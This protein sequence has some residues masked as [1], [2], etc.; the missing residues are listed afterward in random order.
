MHMDNNP[1]NLEIDKSSKKPLVIFGLIFGTIVFLTIWYLN[2]NSD[3]LTKKQL[4]EINRHTKVIDLYVN[5]NEH[6]FLYVKFSNGSEKIMET[7][8]QIGDSLS[9]D[10]G[11]SIEYIFRKDSIIKNNYFEEARKNGQLN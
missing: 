8:Y 9:K 11:D 6:N 5:K 2:Y 1:F 10:K 4:L 7:Y 3:N